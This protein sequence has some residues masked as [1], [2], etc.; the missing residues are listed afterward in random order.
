RL[1]VRSVGTRTERPAPGEQVPVARSAPGSQQA[2]AQVPTEVRREHKVLRPHPPTQTGVPAVV[3]QLTWVLA[4][5]LRVP[6]EELPE[7]PGPPQLC[8]NKFQL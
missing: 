4:T 2:V 7:L 6:L 5:E 8:L 1:G 3:S